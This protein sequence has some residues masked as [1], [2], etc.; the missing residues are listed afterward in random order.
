MFLDKLLESE[1][2]F[3]WKIDV[4]LTVEHWRAK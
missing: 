2:I 3:W 1:L 4:L